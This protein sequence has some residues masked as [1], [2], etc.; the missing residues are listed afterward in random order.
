[1]NPE[2]IFKLGARKILVERFDANETA[3]LERQ[4]TFLRSKV[5]EEVYPDNLAM[6]FIPMATDIPET[7]ETYSWQVMGMTGEAKVIANAS[8]DLP[9]V[10]VSGDERFGKVHT[11]GDSYGWNFMELEEAARVGLD[12]QSRKANAARQAIE[13]QVD[14]IL[15]FGK[16]DSQTNLLT[17]GFVNNAD[18]ESLGIGNPPGDP[19][20]E[21]TDADDIFETFNA[22]ITDIITESKGKFVPDTIALPMH[23]FLIASQIRVGTDNNDKTV[24]RSFLENNPFIKTI[25]PWHKLEGKG[26][27]GTTNRGVVYKRDPLVLEGIAPMPFRQLPPQARNLEFVVPC[28]ARVGG[29]KVYQ[30]QGMRYIDFAQA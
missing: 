9:R 10:D 29:V 21:D 3:F 2:E 20:S 14:N 15:C 11:V 13:L 6:S 17:T 23:E 1:M 7:A 30:P 5:M 22:A 28:V 27:G 26:A 12:L 16:T 19:W 4:L 18:V 24:L 8:D 25:A